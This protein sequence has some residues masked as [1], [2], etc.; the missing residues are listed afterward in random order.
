MYESKMIEKMFKALSP[1]MSAEVEF[2]VLR[3]KK[4]AEENPNPVDDFFATFL[5]EVTGLD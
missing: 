2:S 1:E 4:I 5:L 3:L